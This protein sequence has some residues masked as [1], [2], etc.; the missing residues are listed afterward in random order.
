MCLIK[1]E[2]TSPCTHDRCRHAYMKPETGGLFKSHY[3]EARKDFDSFLKFQG[4]SAVWLLA[5]N[6]YKLGTEERSNFE[7][8]R[9]ARTEIEAVGEWP[10][11]REIFS[12]DE[13]AFEF[14]EYDR[15]D[16]RFNFE[17]NENE[18]IA[19]R[20]VQ[21]VAVYVGKGASDVK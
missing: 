17:T 19:V 7:R 18:R 11:D 12:R 16:F 6:P 20:D 4:S 8:F 5:V 13:V 1:G 14:R 15:I 9:Q 3:I 10:A 21:Q 2:E